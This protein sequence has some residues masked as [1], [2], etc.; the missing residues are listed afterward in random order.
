MVASGARDEG[1]SLLA[2][3]LALT[4][5]EMGEREVL[6]VDA[7]L[8]HPELAELVGAPDRAGPLRRHHRG[9]RRTR[10]GDHR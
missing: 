6:L 1:K 5:L 4:L 7:N 3:N 8:R 10:D 9:R 2:A